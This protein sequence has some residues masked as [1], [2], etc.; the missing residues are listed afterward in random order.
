MLR[1]ILDEHYGHDTGSI[2]P[3]NLREKIL[4]TL[5]ECTNEDGFV[6]PDLAVPKLEA[7]FTAETAAM[8]KALLLVCGL[9]SLALA[10]LDKAEAKGKARY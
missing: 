8:R 7:L 10:I 4:L 9:L 6:L 1:H 5:G 2:E 3:D